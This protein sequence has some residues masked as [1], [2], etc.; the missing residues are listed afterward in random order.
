MI[1]RPLS[2]M[3]VVE[4]VGISSAVHKI[5]H[6]LKIRLIGFGSG[7]PGMNK[8]GDVTGKKPKT[9]QLKM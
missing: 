5:M 2:L 4:A 6:Q 8:F 9:A 7:E 3:F 1:V